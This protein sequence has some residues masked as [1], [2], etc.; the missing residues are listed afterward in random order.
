MK[1]NTNDL[2]KKAEELFNQEKFNE[3]IELLSD[4]KLEKQKNAELYAWKAV[5]NYKLYRDDAVTIFLANKAIETDSNC[6]MG[7]FA[8]ACVWKI[9]KKYDKAKADYDIA[10]DLNPDYAEGYYYRGL[11]WQSKKEKEK[12]IADFDNAEK[13][14]TKAIKNKP[15]NA[16]LYVWRGVVRY[17]KKDY[18]KAI[19]DYDKAI[20]INLNY[21]L[22]FYNRGNAWVAKKKYEKAIL[23]FTKAIDFDSKYADK[24]YTARGNV[25]NVEEKYDDAILDYSQA[26]N[27]NPNDENAYYKR[28]LTYYKKTLEEGNN[29]IELLKRSKKDFEKYLKLAKGE[30]DNSSIYAKQYIAELT[31]VIKNPDLWPIKQLVNDIK[32]ELLIR[33]N[34]GITHYTS[35]SALK[36]L[37]FDN[38][39][40]QISEGNFM[41]DPSEGR[42]LFGFLEY[43]PDANRKDNSSIE[44]FSFKPFIGSFVSDTKR[45]VLNMWR[46]YGKEKGDEAKGCTITINKQKFIDDIK[47]FLSDETNKEARLEDESDINFYRVAYIVHNGKDIFYIPNSNKKSDELKKLMKE[48]KIKIKPYINSCD[49]DTGNVIEKYLNS[50]AFLFKNDA[51]KNEDEVR[52]V[53]NG[54]ELKK[55]YNMGVNPPKIYIELIS[56]KDMISHIILGPK[57]DKENEWK[58]AFYYSYEN[59]VNA[60][61]VK[62]SQV[63]FK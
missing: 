6:F 43:E 62:K 7:Y 40:F 37:I 5:A 29:K 41:N 33:K 11:V 12:A 50:I 47:D 10:I 45:D 32:D 52:L 39:R 38:S 46:F 31:V 18:N 26:I 34:N 57:V 3:V 35:I 59:M 53:M 14:Y 23:D 2:I 22:A 54:I 20:S 58:A 8:R 21:E 60:P 27:K 4:E 1:K 30:K 56:I 28:G 44:K 13:K 49:V 61:K 16:E 51:Y 48:L 42:E 55:K 63:P 25:L 19:K 36:E 15:K 24:Y 9:E 17:V